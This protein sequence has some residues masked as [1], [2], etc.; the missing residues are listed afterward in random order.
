M[1]KANTATMATMNTPLLATP[2]TSRPKTICLVLSMV[3]ILSSTTLV[4]MR[5]YTKTSPS[6]P[7]GL[8]QN[9]CDRAHDQESCLAMVSQIAS[10]TSTKT[11][12]VGLLQLL[13][14][15][16]TPHIQNT[17]EKA[18]VIHSRINDAREQAALGDCVELMEISKYRI[19]DTIVALESVSSRSHANALTWLSSVLTNHDTCLDGLNGPARSTME[20]YLHDL[21]LRARTSLAILAAISPSK[22]N[23][24]IFPLKDDFPSWLL[25]MDRKLL[26]ALPKDINADVTVAKDGSGKYKTVKEAVAS[27]P[28]NG[29]TRYVIYVK[30][31]KYKENVEVGKKKKNVMLVG[32]GMD[33]TI[34]TGNLNVVDGSTTFNSATVAAVGDGFI[35]QDIWFQNTAGPEKHQAVA[36]RVGADQS[37]INRCR[38]DAYQD[39]LYTHSLRQFYRDSYVTGTVDFIF[40][41]AAVVLQNCKLVPRKPMSGQKNMVTAQGRTDPNQNTGTS[42]QKCDIIASSDLT[43]VK[44][45]FKSYLGRPWKEYSRTVV[46]QSN[47]GDL[48]DP[49]GWSAWDGEFALKTLYYGEYLNQGAGAGTSKRVNWPG[50]HVITSAN[51]AK[52]FTVAELIQ[53]GVWLKSTGVSYTEGL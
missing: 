6:S 7:P 32:D 52:K 21:I 14:G 11:S 9:L 2:K 31:G 25:S 3:A 44:S 39:T 29:K 43:P 4:T 53:G 38:I 37:V 16:S 45:S 36:L 1:E 41:N 26:V 30:K 47:I 10:N 49:A 8:L 23:N 15:K 5:Y 22:E 17:I 12:Q 46:M 18:K 13:L 40:G 35:A 19:K 24:E 50:Y 20:P 51:E 28:D 42:I 33:S 27:A 34:I 48:I